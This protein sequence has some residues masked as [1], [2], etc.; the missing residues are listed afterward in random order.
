MLRT[1]CNVNDLSE[2]VRK[3]ENMSVQSICQSIFKFKMKPFLHWEIKL[4]F[5]II[6]SI[7][8]TLYLCHKIC[9]LNKLNPFHYIGGTPTQFIR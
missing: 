2:T 6:S 7:L 9:K 3:L 5:K 1:K 4:Y 8:T